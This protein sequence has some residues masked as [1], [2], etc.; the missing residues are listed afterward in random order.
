MALAGLFD[1]TAK[2]VMRLVS[3]KILWLRGA[4]QVMHGGQIRAIKRPAAVNKKM[5]IDAE[6]PSVNCARRG[7]E[8]QLFRSAVWELFSRAQSRDEHYVGCPINLRSSGRF[9]SFHAEIFSKRRKTSRRNLKQKAEDTSDVVGVNPISP[10]TN[11][12]YAIKLP[13]FA[14]I[15]LTKI[16]LSSYPYL[17]YTIYNSEHA[18]SVRNITNT[19]TTRWRHIS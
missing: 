7:C 13:I 14:V 18:I 10:P 2:R 1:L 12:N 19:R 4:G 17:R 11:R 6:F 5:K 8:I 16:T 3:G 9:E 15:A